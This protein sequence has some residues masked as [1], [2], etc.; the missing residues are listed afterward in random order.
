MN[1]EMWK[2]E[3][4]IIAN[5]MSELGNPLKEADLSPFD[6]FEGGL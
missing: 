4:F 3:N 5:G 2:T 6:Y 1:T